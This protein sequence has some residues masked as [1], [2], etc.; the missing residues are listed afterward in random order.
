VTGLRLGSLCTGYGGLDIAAREVFGGQVAWVSD[1]DPGA[2]RIIAHRM[3]GVPNLGDLTAVDWAGVEPVDVLT[4]GYPCQPFSTAGRRKGTADDRHIWPHIADALRVLRPRHAVFEN[5]AGH[6]RLGF[7]TVLADLAALG[8]DAEWVVV[9]A[10]EVGAPHQRKRLLVLATAADT[11]H[12]G[13]QRGRDA[14]HWRPG[15][16]DSGH[17]AA[18]PGSGIAING[19]LPVGRYPVQRGLRSDAPRCGT[20]AAA[21]TDG[22]QPER[23]GVAG[24]LGGQAAAEPREGDQRE[25][26]GDT[27]GHRGEAAPDADTGGRGTDE[28]NIRP[29]QPH[30]DWG[31]FAPAV[32]RWELV[33]G[34]RAPWATDD[35]RRLSPP[36]VEWLMGL[37]AGH[38][39]DVPGLTRTQQLRALGNGVVP[40][41][42]AAALRLLSE[43]VIASGAVAA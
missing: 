2:R 34:R 38:V 6:L 37:P 19:E 32:A 27:A 15:P 39:T 33:T 10:S 26:A 28:H 5:V 11:P 22:R 13:H 14:R 9:R 7:D 1:V 4:A 36:F 17:A 35:R 23:R 20:S 3:P 40:Q 16:A 8:F 43:R 30:V 18:H 12:L 25:R 21:D 24:V 41:Q 31:R 29:G 42:A